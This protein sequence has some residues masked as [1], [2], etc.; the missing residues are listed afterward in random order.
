MSPLLSKPKPLHLQVEEFVR[1]GIES[2]E[3]PSGSRLPSTIALAKMTG[4]SVF[5][6]QTA[7]VRLAK[8]GLL[9]RQAKRETYVKGDKPVLT[10]VG[11]YFGHSLVEKDWQFYQ[12]LAVLLRE[13]LARHHI[14]VQ[15]WTDDREQAAHGEAL[16]S[17]RRAAERRE[18]QALIAPLICHEDFAWMDELSIPVAYTGRARKRESSQEVLGKEAALQEGVSWLKEQGCRTVGLIHHRSVQKKSGKRESSSWDFANLELFLDTFRK[19]GLGIR[20]EWIRLPD[21]DCA[22]MEKYGFEAFNSL[23]DGAERPDALVVHPDVV[24]K[25]VLTA[26]LGR[27]G[28]VARD[29]K[30]L[31]HVNEEIAYPCP[32]PA[33]WLSVRIADVADGLIEAVRGRSGQAGISRVP[34]ISRF[35]P[36]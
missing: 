25:G 15:I 8:E 18:I 7:L 27:G 19:N 3:F 22:N 13:K 5:T 29:L 24:A 10:C 33:S 32:I 6:V 1:A 16:P 31:M 34:V 2:G 35:L 9:D 12:S 21:G 26:V 11:I 20:N 17:L 14:R 30:L 4:V 36:E 28:S 23:W